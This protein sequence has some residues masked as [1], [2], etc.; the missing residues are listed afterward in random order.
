MS[1]DYRHYRPIDPWGIYQDTPVDTQVS[2]SKPFSMPKYRSPV[3]EVEAV[4][5]ALHSGDI[6]RNQACA[7]FGRD[8]E[9]VDAE[10]AADKAKAKHQ[11]LAAQFESDIGLIFECMNIFEFE[12]EVRAI[13]AIYASI[14]NTFWANAEGDE[15]VLGFRGASSMV[16]R[17]SKSYGHENQFYGCAR[18]GSVYPPFAAMMER[19]GWTYR[20]ALDDEVAV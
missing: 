20:S 16:H 6:T 7:L 19:L 4:L 12:T 15:I 5:K 18:E 8:V 13:E 10:I 2:S 3:E 1:G 11:Q 17:V 9:E 14:T